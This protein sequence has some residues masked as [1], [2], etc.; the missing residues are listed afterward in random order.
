LLDNFEYQFNT[1]NFAAT[2]AYYHTK[3]EDRATTISTRITPETEGMIL[4]SGMDQLNK[5]W[6]FS[7]SFLPI[8]QFRLDASAWLG[9]WYLTD[10]VSAVY[11][12]YSDPDATDQEFNA[13]VKDLKVG[14]MPQA[15]LTLT[16]TIMPVKGASAAF[17]VHTY[18]SHYAN[19]NPFDRQKESDAGIQ[20]WKIPSHTVCDLHMSYDIPVK[21]WE[22][23]F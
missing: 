16:A 21:R 6:E 4:V 8:K 20:P 5:G 1:N 23:L 15:G 11:K 14:D 18:R 2:V 17:V 7:M 3:W 10:D 22:R 12:D 19:W 9:D 13:Y